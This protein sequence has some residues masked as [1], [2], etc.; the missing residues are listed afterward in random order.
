MSKSFLSLKN[1]PL[2]II[3]L[4]LL[5]TQFSAMEAVQAQTTGVAPLRVSSQAEVVPDHYIVVYKQGISAASVET[6]IRAEVAAQGGEV[7]FIYAAALNGYAAYLPAQALAAV[8]ANPAVDYVEA[9]TVIKL[10][11]DE[12]KVNTNEVKTNISEPNAVWGLDRIDQRNLPLSTTYEYEKTGT[13]VNV[14]VI[15]TGIRS[16]H[17]EFGGRASKDHDSIGDGQDGN[18]CDGHG[19]HVAGTIGGATYGVAKSVTIH[20]VRVLDCN[21]SAYASQVIDGVNWVTGNRIK[22]AVA[23]MSLGGWGLASLDTAVTNMIASGVVLVVAAGNSD[24]NACNYSPAR[25]PG[26]ITVGATEFTDERA[27]YSNWGTC[28]DIF[29]PG[30]YITSAWNAGDTV[31]NTISGTSM[32]S[33]HVAGV[34]ALYLED[35]PDATPGI[36]RN[37]IVNTST[38]NLVTNPGSGSPNILLY[39]LFGPVPPIPNPISPSGIIVDRTPTYKW[40]SAPGATQYSYEIWRNEKLLYTKVVGTSVCAKGICAHTPAFPLVYKAD[41]I[42]KVRA[43][44]NGVWE[45]YSRTLYFTVINSATAFNSPFTRNANGWIALKGGW[46]V[47]NGSYYTSGLYGYVSTSVHEGN[48]ATLDYQLSMSRTGCE[49]CSNII[50]IRGNPKPLDPYRYWW[51]EGYLFMYTNS[52]Y[53]SIWSA[54]NGYY[55]P[56]QYWTKATA[57]RKGTNLIRIKA[58]GDQLKFYINNKRVW[59]GTDTSL[60]FGKVGVGFYKDGS[61]G[62]KLYV[63]WARVDLNTANNLSSESDEIAEVGEE[64]T[65]WTSLY[66]ALP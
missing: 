1:F 61:G 56:I 5:L 64:M 7:K 20:A 11:D 48:Y 37:T 24:D 31:I 54:V 16:T 58:N 51:Y 43:L 25:V 66:Q 27:S 2:I 41:Y 18:D 62:N 15:D 57:I 52:G 28:V 8:R 22:P 40:K 47:K 36:V 42:W 26:A 49:S 45:S 63:Q 6:T 30:S 9:D 35:H 46:H 38:P 34:A 13:G 3:I 60:S 53:F 33:P 59:A 17:V 21:G 14:Y 32:A 44:A 10:P 55:V 50:Y 19:T 29:A 12:L 65:N 39:S 4:A 23:N